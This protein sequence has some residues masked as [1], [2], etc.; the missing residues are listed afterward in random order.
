MSKNGLRAESN[1]KGEVVATVTITTRICVH[2]RRPGTLE[3]PMDELTIYQQGAYV[4]D[5]FTSLNAGER[6][7]II[8]GTHPACWDAMFG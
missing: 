5:A 3:V 1:K 6:E 4:Q 8:T 2:C 7:Q